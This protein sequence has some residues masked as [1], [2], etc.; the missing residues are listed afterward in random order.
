MS[1]KWVHRKKLNPDRSIRYKS[2]LV[3]R[4]F[5]QQKG[6]DYFNTYAPTMSLGSMRT[7][8]ACAASRKMAV[9]NVDINTAYLFGTLEVPIYMAIPKGYTSKN[10]KEKELIRQGDAVC[11]LKRSL[12][13]LKQSAHVC[14]EQDISIVN[15]NGFC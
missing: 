15:S 1:C 3:A 14:L 6:I 5:T 12:Y 13:G 4:G 8:L 9:H 11:L 10:E 2:R 7:I